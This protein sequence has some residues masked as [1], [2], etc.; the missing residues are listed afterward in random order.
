M[1]AIRPED[2]E[3]LLTE[4]QSTLREIG[5]AAGLWA[6]LPCTCG[7]PDCEIEDP[8]RHSVTLQLDVL[9]AGWSTAAA[10]AGDG[11]RLAATLGRLCDLLGLPGDGPA[12][13]ADPYSML[14]RLRERWL[15]GMGTP[16]GD[17]PPGEKWLT[18]LYRVEAR[19]RLLLEKL[20][21]RLVA[22]PFSR[23]AN[24]GAAHARLR[25]LRTSREGVTGVVRTLR[26]WIDDDDTLPER[27][28]LH[29]HLLALVAEAPWSPVE[30]QDV[31]QMAE[32]AAHAVLAFGIAADTWVSAAYGAMELIAPHAAL[33]MAL[34]LEEDSLTA[35]R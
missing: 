30:R 9:G 17:G 5:A 7:R 33:R 18:D 12:P 31:A 22:T 1:T 11:P 28:L 15:A 4:T 34:L 6:G 20:L 13:D 19:N 24:A 21:E 14:H 32:D 35:P 23:V 3:S 8:A 10:R 27:K 16:L 26:I 25:R 2:L 29:E